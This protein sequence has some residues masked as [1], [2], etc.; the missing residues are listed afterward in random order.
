[1]VRSLLMM[2]MVIVLLVLAV[3][4]RGSDEC[5]GKEENRTDQ[6]FCG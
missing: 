4:G 1:M 2:M 3:V 6:V 5:V